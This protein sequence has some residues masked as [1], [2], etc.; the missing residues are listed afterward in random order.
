MRDVLSM[1]RKSHLLAS[2]VLAF[3]LGVAAGPVDAA[4]DLGSRKVDIA[5][6]LAP[7]SDLTE[8]YPG[9]DLSPGFSEFKDQTLRQVMRIAIGGD[10]LK[11]KFSNEYG[12]TPLTLDVVRIAA[13]LGLGVIDPA[14]SVPVIFGGMAQVTLAPGKEVYSDEIKIASK[15]FSEFAVS[16]YMKR[17]DVRTAHRFSRNISYIGAGDLTLATDLPNAKRSTASF[18][19]PE[20]VAVRTG[21]PRVIVAFGD[22]ITDYTPEMDGY[23]DWPDQLQAIAHTNFDVSVVDAGIGGNRWV[24][25]NMGPCGVCRFKRDVL[26]I[27]GV[28]DVV[29][30]NG[31][32]DLGLSY[33][34]AN[35]FKNPD[36]V[37]TA[38]QII[39]AMQKA[40]EMAKAKGLRVY[41]ATIVPFKGP[42]DSKASSDYYTSGQA[43]EV[44]F[45]KTEPL[46]GEQMRQE[47]NSFIRTDK[48]IDG[49]IDIDRAIA[50]PTDPL[51][52]RKDLSRDGL[53]PNKDGLALFAQLA[54]RA[55]FRSQVK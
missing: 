45:G 31:V 44:P 2:I 5:T 22:S 52:E 8:P 25:N 32:N 24:R 20:I 47:V 19:L 37:V 40:I 38:K 9:L 48:S 36:E 21:K 33:R 51:R 35:G 49:V 15:A 34:Y 30:V 50:D 12:T 14:T 42:P 17:A 46:N 41:A 10:G 39:G 55:I 43:N 3:A 27:E 13:S 1:R 11:I 4:S 6:Y 16:I 7:Q 23:E 26:D 28:T 18:Y 54:Y 53:H 29:L